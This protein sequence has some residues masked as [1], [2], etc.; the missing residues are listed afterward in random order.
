MSGEWGYLVI[1]EGVLI[2]GAV[3]AFGFWEL[4]KLKKLRLERE[5]QEREAQ[6]RESVHA[7][8]TDT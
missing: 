2:F 1:V 7:E 6:E 8:K 4:H 5:A 3:L